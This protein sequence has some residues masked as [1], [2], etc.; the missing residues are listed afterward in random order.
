MIEKKSTTFG[1]VEYHCIVEGCDAKTTSP[2]SENPRERWAI[3]I[4]V[5]TSG[6]EVKFADGETLEHNKLLINLCP[7]CAQEYM[8]INED[9][10]T[11]ITKTEDYVTEYIRKIQPN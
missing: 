10:Y 11:A 5:D 6:E 8:G 2:F 9:V 1:G 7:K 3:G 4:C